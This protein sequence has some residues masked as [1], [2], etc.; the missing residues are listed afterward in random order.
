MEGVNPNLSAIQERHTMKKGIFSTKC[1]QGPL[2]TFKYL[3][4]LRQPSQALSIRGILYSSFLIRNST[5]PCSKES[6]IDMLLRNM[7][8]EKVSKQR[9]AYD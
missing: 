9:N 4:G 5:D 1:Y 7:N 3:K 6:A 2:F 8:K